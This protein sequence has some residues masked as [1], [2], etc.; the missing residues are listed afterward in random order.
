MSKTGAGVRAEGPAEAEAAIRRFLSSARQPVLV[1]PG[2]NQ[3]PLEESS[4]SLEWRGSRFL[5][6]VWDETRNLARRVTGVRDERPGKLE[7][8]IER[9]GGEQGRILLL[10]LSRSG[11]AE[12][13][14][15]ARLVWREEF[16]R[17][18][19]RQFPDWRIA[20]LSSEPNLEESLSPAYPRAL[21]RNGT[22]GRAAIFSP[23][24]AGAAAGAVTFGLVWL[25]YLRR[26]ERRLAIEGL[27]LFVPQAEARAAYLR[28]PFLNPRAA[29]FDAFVYTA[30]GYEDRFDPADYGNLETELETAATPLLDRAS[31]VAAAVARIS[32]LPFVEKIARNDGA[33]SL[34]VRGIE[35]A[36]ATRS[37]LLY[38]LERKTVAREA[39]LPEVEALAREL[40]RLRTA[41][42]P[43]R[44][45]PLWRQQPEAW[46]ESEVRAHLGA[47]DPSL[48]PEP[49][50]GQ[51]PAIAGG[52][53]GVIDLLA[54][55][56]DGRLAVLEL[57]ASEDIHL[58]LQALDYWMRVR[59][60]AEHGEFSRK[61]Y[62][63]GLTLRQE[64]PRLL[65][66]APALSFHPKTE[67][68]LRYFAPEIEVERIGLG[69]EWRQG[70]RVMFRVQGDR[71]PV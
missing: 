55:G 28:L 66:I 32:D 48:C 17:S 59:W 6:E 46:L 10:D 43:D 68:I 40:A 31:P 71:Q 1:E 15:G 61:G 25:D 50:Y 12:E 69:V 52:D 36:R 22:T 9:F 37:G 5:V 45:N 33:L 21:I 53:R 56:R 34:R 19:H 16:R 2:E 42:A 3:F 23:P 35:F 27:A 65:L 7:L 62:S 44:A 49:V 67:T 47:I 4:Y 63:P 57:K 20:G 58:P 41:G 24:E 64:W 13:R 60:H 38:G 11:R 54:A 26:R 51:V 8:T 29:R 30:E 18:L 70:P 39:S 14:R